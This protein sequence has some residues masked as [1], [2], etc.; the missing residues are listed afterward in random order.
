MP[1]DAVSIDTNIF[2]QHKLNLESGLL[3]QLSQFKEGSHKLLISDIVLREVQQHM[4]LQAQRAAENFE[5]YLQACQK[6]GVIR[7][8]MTTEATRILN[9]LAEPSSAVESRI[10]KWM[11]FTGAEII[12]SSL[13]SMKD[14]LKMYFDSQP[15]FDKLGEKKSEFP[16]AIALLSIDAWALSNEA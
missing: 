10:R 9:S 7:D 6:T 12:S 5:K 15:P 16:D 2:D 8:H 14:V 1:Y 4:L 13:A 11:Q 3:A